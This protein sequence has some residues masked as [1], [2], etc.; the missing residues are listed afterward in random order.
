MILIDGS[1]YGD[2]THRRCAPIEPRPDTG[3]CVGVEQGDAVKAEPLALIL[4]S[5]THSLCADAQ[6][7]PAV[8][9]VSLFP[10]KDE[11]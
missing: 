5:A 1:P 6:V 9:A 8:S 4:P 11:M 10:R 2:P 7:H 3:V